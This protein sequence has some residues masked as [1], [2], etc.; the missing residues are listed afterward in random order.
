MLLLGG[1]DPNAELPSGNTPLIIAV[2]KST[3]NMDLI[4]LLLDGDIILNLQ[5]TETP[6]V[7]P[8]LGGPAQ[9]VRRLLNRT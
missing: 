9:E 7:A 4:R 2:S 5:D 8:F 3:P 1:A 6:I